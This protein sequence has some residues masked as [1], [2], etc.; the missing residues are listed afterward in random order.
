VT[1]VSSGASGRDG[2]EPAPRFPVVRSGGRSSDAR[3]LFA[4]HGYARDPWAVLQLAELVDPGGRFAHVA[5]RGPHPG[6]D[7]ATFYRVDFVTRT[8]DEASFV[9]ALGTLGR[10]FDAVCADGGF[11][12]A[13]AVLF[14]FSQGA[15][16]ALAL[17]FGRSDR[18]PPAAVVALSGPLHPAHRVD[19]DDARARDVAVFLAHGDHDPIFDPGQRRAAAERFAAAGAQVTERTYP[20]G[21]E[22]STEELSE[23]REWLAGR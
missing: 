19:W 3:L 4:V 16:L 12:P 8:L 21:H 7:G 22:V 18:P 5:P 2:V 1:T 6:G 14:G 13:A 17:A 10:T 23:V 15:G 9:E 11:D 20:F